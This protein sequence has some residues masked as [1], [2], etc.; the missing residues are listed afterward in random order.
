MVENAVKKRSVHKSEHRETSVFKKMTFVHNSE[1][2]VQK[3]YEK[4]VSKIVLKN[5]DMKL[6]SRIF[7]HNLS[8]A[9]KK[10]PGRCNMN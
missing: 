10:Q 7:F 5:E 6:S 8:N 9:L 4:M 3:P 2:L 1:K